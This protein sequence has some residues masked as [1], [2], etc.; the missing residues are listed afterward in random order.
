MVQHHFLHIMGDYVRHIE[1]KNRVAIILSLDYDWLVGA[2]A[3]ML[4]GSSTEDDDGRKVQTE[5]NIWCD[6][7]KT[8]KMTIE[9]AVLWKLEQD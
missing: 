7:I 2:W 3:V 4:K 9:E 1:C 5:P 8:K 6:A